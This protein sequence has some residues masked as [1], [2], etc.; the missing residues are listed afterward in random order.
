MSSGLDSGTSAPST[1]GGSELWDR[2][3]TFGTSLGDSSGTPMETGRRLTCRP[4][5]GATGAA[6][7]RY[8]PPPA[9]ESG[10]EGHGQANRALRGLRAKERS[11]SKLATVDGSVS[12]VAKGLIN[13]RCQRR[14]RLIRHSTS[15]SSCSCGDGQV[16][17]V[18]QRIS[19][20]CGLGHC[21]VGLR[22][23]THAF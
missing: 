8:G 16:E 9:R 23:L 5:L 11:T 14:V 3:V 22:G 15:L 7:E 1:L 6:M 17:V 18:A 2:R 21:A 13:R 4:P 19:T 10:G 20:S 12:Y